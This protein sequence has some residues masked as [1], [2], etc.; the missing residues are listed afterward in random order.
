V[1][2]RVLVRS[3]IPFKELSTVASTTFN[4]QLDVTLPVINENQ[5]L[6]Y[7]IQAENSFT[8]KLIE[9]LKEELASYSKAIVDQEPAAFKVL[10]EE[11]RE[12]LN[13]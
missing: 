8:P 10:M 7:E 3:G 5:D 2:A 6:Y 1:F 4:T 9:I 12:Y 13:K 11:S